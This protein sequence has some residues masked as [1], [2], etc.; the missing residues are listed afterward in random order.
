MVESVYHIED[1]AIKKGVIVVNKDKNNNGNGKHKGKLGN[2]N[3][4]VVNDGVVD[5]PKTK[6]PT[7]KLFNAIYATKQQEGSKPQ[8]FDK[9]SKFAKNGMYIHPWLSL[10][11]WS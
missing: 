6:K 3:K 10:M 1:V 4:Y 2:K 5:P 8:T 11:R 7:F 9:S